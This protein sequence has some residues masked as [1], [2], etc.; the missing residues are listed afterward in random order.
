VAD[1]TPTE[2]LRTLWSASATL[3]D[4]GYLLVRSSDVLTLDDAGVER[5]ARA[6]FFPNDDES[7]R[8]WAV[9]IVER[10]RGEQR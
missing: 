7:Y 1:L 2:A 4:G 8:S 10:L 9:A 3:L 6:L 5:L